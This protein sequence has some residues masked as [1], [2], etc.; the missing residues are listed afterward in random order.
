MTT[1][2]HHQN[3]Q[4]STPPVTTAN[5]TGCH[6]PAPARSSCRKDV[7]GGHPQVPL[8][9]QVPRP[10]WRRERSAARQVL[11]R[12]GWED[13]AAWIALASWSFTAICQEGS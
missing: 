12:Q 11:A 1:G 7:D 5:H 9:R 8:R 3:P 10:S 13:Q 6:A 2:D 4:R